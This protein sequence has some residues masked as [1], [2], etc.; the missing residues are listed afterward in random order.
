MEKKS[1]TQLD[2]ARRAG[3][4]VSVVSRVL[5]ISGYVAKE[6]KERILQREDE[7]NYALNQVSLRLQKRRTRQSLFY[8]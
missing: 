4:S 3:K 1:A 8:C 6:K 7:M 2:I 5:N